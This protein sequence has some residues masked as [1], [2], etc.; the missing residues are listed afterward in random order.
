MQQFSDSMFSLDLKYSFLLPEK[1]R[2]AHNAS[3]SVIQRSVKDL[4]KATASQSKPENAASKK[5][6]AVEKLFARLSEL[7]LEETANELQENSMKIES[8]NL[9]HE[10]RVH[11]E[12]DSVEGTSNNHKSV[13]SNR[14]KENNCIRFRHTSDEERNSVGSVPES[15][16]F[17]LGYFFFDAPCSF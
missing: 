4:G 14:G 13:H 16:V 7:E 3:H 8:L 1:R 6:D 12:E 11:F 15:K 9:G 10:T 2:I 5:D 17:N